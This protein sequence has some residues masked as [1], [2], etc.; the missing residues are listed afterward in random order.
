MIIVHFLVTKHP[1]FLLSVSLMNKFYYKTKN[2][3]NAFCFFVLIRLQIFLGPGDNIVYI[4]IIN[5]CAYIYLFEFVFVFAFYLCV[6]LFH[7]K[8]EITSFR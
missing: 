8:G 3:F 7:K 5:I 4:A 2:V 6:L 1:N